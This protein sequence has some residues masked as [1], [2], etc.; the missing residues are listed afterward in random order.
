MFRKALLLLLPFLL[1][2][3]VTAGG[4]M[5][6][7]LLLEN[8]NEAEMKEMG[9]KISAKDIYDINN[10]SLKDAIVHFGGFCTGEVISSK[11]L[12]LTNHHCG[13]TAIQSHSTLENNYLEDGFWAA[14]HAQEIPNP[15]LFVTFIDRIEDVTPRVLDGVYADTPEA[16]RARLVAENLRQLREKYPLKEHEEL[17]VKPFYDGNQYFAFVTK[18][19]TDIRLVGAPPSS[20]GKFGADTDNWEWPRHTG[21]F[22][23]FRIYAAPDGSPAAY[24]SDNV[25]YTPKKH[26]EISLQGLQ[27][28]DFSMVFGF[29]GTTDQYL[30]ASAMQQRTEVLNPIRIGMRDLSLAVIDSAMRASA[31]V[32]IDYASKQA[33]IA[34]AW[35]KWR[36]ESEGVAAVNA[37]AQ[38]QDLEKE[39]LRR[40]QAKPAEAEIYA[41]LLPELNA[42]V[43]RQEAVAKTRAYVGEMN[44]NIDLFRVA[45]FLSGQ[46][47]IA[48]SNGLAAFRERVP[49]IVA[50]LEEFYTGYHPGIDQRVAQALIP[51][52]LDEVPENHQSFYVRDQVEFAGSRQKLINDLFERS[53]LTRGARLI[54]LLQDNP[55]VAVDVINGDPAYQFVLQLNRFNEKEVGE[56]YNEIAQRMAPLQRKY[57]AGLM[58]FFPERRFYPD[59]NSTLRVSYGKFEGFTGLD[60]KTFDFMTDLDGVIAKYIPGNYEFDVPARLRE[61]HA[62]KDY[63]R[64]A[65]ADGKL[66]VCI[67]GSNHTTGGNSGSP[68]LDANGRLV[69]L[70]FD[71]TWQSTMSDVHYD[72]SIC[73]N[74]MVDIRYVLF[75][76][77]K[78]GGAPHLVEEMTLV[79]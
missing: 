25:P 29:P 62:A 79:N 14:N 6:L 28:G 78:F 50:F 32:K 67:L 17:L 63:G 71:R 21:D 8:L 18:K 42:L 41:P 75:L 7:P 33:R 31:Q 52:Y 64:Y 9:M 54:K 68:A 59:A 73:R 55:D 44:Y 36:G 69:G 58:T 74:I 23:L 46:L 15:G 26:L 4:G 22:S 3:F 43:V 12:V 66:P 37:I 24:S 47:K 65:T 5:W 39:F 16:E 1:P 77:D 61:L 2:L 10:G 13:F 48:Q 19:Y 20:I 51:V 34:N 70:N 76:I 27:P 60:G 49:G 38:R 11:G 57:L 30:P 35:K 40:L 56:P 72:P 53:Y 45:S